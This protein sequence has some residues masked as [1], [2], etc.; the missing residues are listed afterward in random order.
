MR[1]QK[2]FALKGEARG[3]ARLVYEGGGG[4]L[5]VDIAPRGAEECEAWLV[6]MKGQLLR[7]PLG[8]TMT[9]AVPPNA[10]EAAGVFIS[11]AGKIIASGSNGLPRADMES[12]ALRVQLALAHDAKKARLAEQ[13][14]A[15]APEKPKTPPAAATPPPNA[16]TPK[17]A[18]PP[19][20]PVREN[21]TE[22]RIR[23]APPSEPAAQ[24]NEEHAAVKSSVITAKQRAETRENIVMASR[25]HT[26]PFPHIQS[27]D[28]ARLR[29]ERAKRAVREAL[30]DPKVK[31]EAAQSIL[32]MANRLFYPTHEEDTPNAFIEKE[33]AAQKPTTPAP[34]QGVKRSMNRMGTPVPPAQ[35]NG[36]YPPARPGNRRAPRGRFNRPR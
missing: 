17:E 15:D 14:P 29:E 4:T 16:E 18:K 23:Y 20:V 13:K 33:A 25:A 22:V 9:A 5:S 24:P 6:P 19:D 35:K 30:V 21:Q 10:A 32:S 26:T 1:S 27:D 3:A 34:G 2:L 36:A 28:M 7:A 8:P 31:S 11:R 12:A